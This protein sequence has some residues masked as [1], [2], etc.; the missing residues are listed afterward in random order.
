MVHDTAAKT[1]RLRT[2]RLILAF[3]MFVTPLHGESQSTS[4]HC[5]VL[6]RASSAFWFPEQSWS[7]QVPE[8]T[9]KS[10]PKFHIAEPP[11]PERAGG[12]EFFFSR[13]ETTRP[14]VREIRYGRGHESEARFLHR[15]VDAVF[16]VWPWGED[17]WQVA[18]INFTAKKATI[19]IV[20]SGATG[21]GTSAAIADCK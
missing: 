6:A 1:S 16:L 10:L 13:L 17:Q 15:A 4:V 8:G 20:G 5:Q 18:A 3:G 21:V 9:R 19:G 7:G 14:I 12:T 11:S 2:I